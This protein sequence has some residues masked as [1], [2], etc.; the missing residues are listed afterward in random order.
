MGAQ[1]ENRDRRWDP[2]LARYLSVRGGVSLH[3]T[4]LRSVT[5]P[6]GDAAVAAGYRGREAAFAGA[7]SHRRPEEQVRN[8]LR[9]TLSAALGLLPSARA[10]GR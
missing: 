9:G 3:G 5:L 6:R 1:R 4:L 7:A 2:L 10:H 8:Q